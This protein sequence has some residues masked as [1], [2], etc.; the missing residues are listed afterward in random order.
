MDF[1]FCLFV[2]FE[3]IGFEMST[4]H[5]KDVEATVGYTS[6]EGGRHHARNTNLSH[7]LRK[8]IGA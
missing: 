4:E 3:H 6:L 2:C 8:N 1:W 5:L 7:V